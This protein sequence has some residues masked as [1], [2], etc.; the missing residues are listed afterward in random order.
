MICSS[1][2][3]MTTGVNWQSERGLRIIRVTYWLKNG[4]PWDGAGLLTG[5]AGNRSAISTIKFGNSRLVCKISRC[6]LCLIPRLNFSSFS[7]WNMLN[8]DLEFGS[9]GEK[10]T[11]PAGKSCEDCKKFKQC[12]V[13]HGAVSDQVV[14]DWPQLQ[15]VS[16]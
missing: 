5:C 6:R 9:M 8:Q 2:N 10:P 3:R 16:K 14:C 12:R 4:L 7:G 1:R 15:F 11:L 13:I